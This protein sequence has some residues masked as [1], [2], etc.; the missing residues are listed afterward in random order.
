[1]ILADFTCPEHGRFEMLAESDAESA[2]CPI[3]EGRGVPCELAS[4]WSPTPI[5][6][7]VRIGEVERGGVDKPASP[8]MLDTRELG[9]GMPYD[10]WR[11]KRDRMYMERR[12]KESKEI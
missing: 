8:M 4:P 10:Q 9:E 3:T 1:M 2:P 7:R 12:H 5:R 11:E 6:C